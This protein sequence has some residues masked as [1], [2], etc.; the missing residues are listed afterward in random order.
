MVLTQSEAQRATPATWVRRLCAAASDP[1]D[2]GAQALRRSERPPRLGSAG[3]APG[4]ALLTND[5][6]KSTMEKK[7]LTERKRSE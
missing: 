1:R 3:S 5:V 7:K 4:S 6:G 2:L